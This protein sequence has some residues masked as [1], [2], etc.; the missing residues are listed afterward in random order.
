MG[1]GPAEG[2]RVL[3]PP[4]SKSCIAVKRDF[5]PLR[6]AAVERETPQAV[7][8]TL[9]VPDALKETFAYMPGQY[10]TLR[11][12]INGQEVRRT[13]SLCSSPEQ[14][15]WQ[16]G[17]KKVP[18]GLFSTWAN[19][20]LQAGMVLDVMPP[21]GRFFTPEHLSQSSHLLAMAAGSGITP[22]LSIVRNVL[23]TLPHI[24]VSLVYGNQS[25]ATIM[26][27][28]AL[29]ALKNQYIHRFQL[30]HI[31]SR[32]KTESPLHYGRIDEGKCNELL[33]KL[34]PLPADTACYLCG[35]Q[36]MTTAL[37]QLLQRRSIPMA[38]V[39]TELFSAMPK[40]APAIAAPAVPDADDMCSME[41][42]ADGVHRHIKVGYHSHSLLDAALL[43]GVELPYACKGGMCCTCKARLLEGEV[44]MEVHYG[45]EPDEIAQGYILTCQSHPLTPRV[46][47]D[48]D[49]R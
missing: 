28:E 43:D 16:V 36:A 48:Y 17:V 11:A 47:V 22:I 42:I 40:G 33:Q 14:G 18:G 8:I 21:M 49:Q 13:Y 35:P 4:H 10:L 9:E 46:V 20:V 5:Y 1:F 12:T 45:L 34:I 7:A 3:F 38:Q 31:L 6:V 26:F 41:L 32:E 29:E 23:A 27:R 2:V 15:I 37:Q 44:H 30:I 19:E 25:R 24:R 39:H